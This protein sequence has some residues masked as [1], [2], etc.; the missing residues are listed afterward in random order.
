MNGYHELVNS[1]IRYFEQQRDLFGKTVFTLNVEPAR[2]HSGIKKTQES[3]QMFEESVQVCCKCSLGKTRHQL[4][5]GTGNSESNLMLIGE[6][7]GEDED[8]QGKPFVGRA[9]QLLDKMLK[10][11]DFQRS[12]IYIA[13]IIK[14]RPP[15]NRSP[16]SKEIENCLP[17]L[18]KQI[19]L[20]QPKMIVTLGRIAAQT[21][22]GT[23]QSI[24]Q[25]RGQIHDLN[26]IFVL[27]TY[28]PAGLLRNEQWKRPAWDDLQTL[29]KYYDTHVG[30]KS[31]WSG[32]KH[33]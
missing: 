16:N 13:N 17:I 30:D 29:R 25:L 15:G 19:Q 23:S 7:P 21:L 26:G 24:N 33:I 2:Y 31:E 1:S 22:L 12:E 10:A 32:S 27:V 20:I 3:L 9:G 6:A 18:L 28:H 8:K 4:V 14:C 11:I 5:F